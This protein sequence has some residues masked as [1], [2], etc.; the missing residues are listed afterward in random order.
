MSACKSHSLLFDNSCDALFPLTP[1]TLVRQSFEEIHVFLKSLREYEFDNDDVITQLELM[2]TDLGKSKLHTLPLSN[3]A[4]LHFLPRQTPQRFP[5]PPPM[6][7][8]LTVRATRSTNTSSSFQ[9][10]AT[11]SLPAN[12]HHNLEPTSS[13]PA[14]TSSS[15]AAVTTTPLQATAGEEPRSAP[16]E[17][18]D[19]EVESSSSKTT[20]PAAGAEK[21]GAEQTRSNSSTIH[22]GSTDSRTSLPAETSEPDVQD[23]EQ[24]KSS[25]SATKVAATTSKESLPGKMQSQSATQPVNGQVENSSSGAANGQVASGSPASADSR[26]LMVSV[27]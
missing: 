19:K 21:Q 4:S 2:L 7:R 24:A 10:S 17:T 15:S 20:L 3:T 12:L 11:M 18:S 25:L 22:A 26:R 5:E 8:T 23:T 27:L 9:P 13:L 16:A 6:F 14:K 1:E